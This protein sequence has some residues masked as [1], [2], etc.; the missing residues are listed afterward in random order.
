MNEKQLQI[1]ANA[2]AGLADATQEE[3]DYILELL[4]GNVIS[5]ED[6]GTIKEIIKTS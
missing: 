6:C 3:I 2:I 5:E 4:S 1:A